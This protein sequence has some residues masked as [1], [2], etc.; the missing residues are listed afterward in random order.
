ML[1]QRAVLFVNPLSGPQIHHILASHKIRIPTLAPRFDDETQE[2]YTA[3]LKQIHKIDMAIAELRKMHRVRT[4]AIK[5]RKAMAER[6][7]SATNTPAG[8]RADLLADKIAKK[9]IVAVRKL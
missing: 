7:D 4:N 5:A 9:R 6:S 8:R 3:R 2:Q 1:R